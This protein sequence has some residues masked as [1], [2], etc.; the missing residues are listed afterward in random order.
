MAAA[1]ERVGE[2]GAVEAGLENDE[3]A[4]NDNEEGNDSGPP[5]AG[6]TF[7]NLNAQASNV[8]T[9]LVIE[10]AKRKKMSG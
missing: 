1:E 8:T 7:C 4:G 9:R 6:L 5:E 10:N 3:D 2:A